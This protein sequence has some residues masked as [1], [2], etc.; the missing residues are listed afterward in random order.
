VAYRYF[1]TPARKFII[2]DTP[3]HEQ[4][5]RNMATGASTADLAIILIDARKGVI[6][7]TRRHSFIVSLLGIKHVVIAINKMDLVD[8]D[9]KVFDKIK[10]DFLEFSAELDLPNK[11]FI[12]VS[13]LKGDNV[14]DRS[15]NMDWFTEKP[16]LERLEH[17]DATSVRNFNDFRFP[18]QY[19][20]RPNLDFRGFSGT[21]ASG[22]IKVGDK[23]T[24]LPSRRESI[25]KEIVTADGNLEEAFSPQA[26]TIVLNDEI[27]ISSGDM[28]VKSNNLPKVSNLLESF[29][30]WMNEEPLKRGKTYLIRHAGRTTKARI[31]TLKYAV[32]VNTLEKK[33]TDELVLNGIGRVIFSTTKPVPMY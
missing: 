12:P 3:G 6:T 24:A 1:S 13:A 31:E 9:Q 32:D 14:V 20:N 27:D 33:E 25:V 15:T 16:L 5:T 2:A 7:Q 18:V 19:V 29:T 22:T 21:V 26:V 30:V 17:V 11:Y 23:I 28:I 8:F 4:Y 10:A